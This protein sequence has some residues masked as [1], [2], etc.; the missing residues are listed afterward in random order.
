MRGPDSD[1]RNPTDLPLTCT[2]RVRLAAHV[3]MRGCR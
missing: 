2:D 3:T 1:R